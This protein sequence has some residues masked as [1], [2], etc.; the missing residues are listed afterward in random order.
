[1]GS[2]QTNGAEYGTSME[3][4][5]IIGLAT[6][7]PQDADSTENLWKFL[8]QGRSAHTPFPRNKINP[9]GHYH[10][11]PEHGGTVSLEIY[12]STFSETK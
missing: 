2:I 4:I 6:R 10:V 1:M 7:F 5:A 11:D 3:P 9:D 12:P 8:L